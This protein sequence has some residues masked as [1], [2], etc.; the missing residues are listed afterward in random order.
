[1]AQDT[2]R[3]AYQMMVCPKL[4]YPLAVT[5][6]SQQQCDAISSPS[7]RA[8]LAKM[9]YNPNSPKVVYGLR[10]LFG[11]GLHDYYVEQGIRQLSTLVGHICQESETGKMIRIELQ[12]CQVQAGTATHLLTD[13]SPSI[14][15]IETCWIMSI[16]DFLRTYNLRLDFSTAV[17]PVLQCARD[18]FI[19]DALRV[20]GQ[21][22]AIELQHLNACRLFLQV[23]R[24][25]DIASADGLFLRRDALLGSAS[26]CYS[27][28]TRW[29]RQGHPPDVWWRLWR[30]KLKLVFSCNGVSSSLRSRLGEWYSPLDVTEWSIL[31]TPALSNRE[32]FMRRTDG[33]YDIFRH[34]GPAG[35][36]FLVSTHPVGIVDSLPNG[37]V[38]ASLG[39]RRKDGS[40]RVHFRPLSA[41]LATQRPVVPSSTFR[42]YVVHQEPHIARLLHHA[43]LSDA[44]ALQ[45]AN[46]ISACSID[47]G[48]DGG[49]L[50]D[51][52]TFGYIWGDEAS[53]SSVGLGRGQVPGSPISMSSTRTELCGILASLTHLRLVIQHCHVVIP[54]GFSCNF[55][56]DSKAA[57]QRVKDLEYN[58][59]GTTWRCRANY[60]MEAA[61]RHCLFLLPVRITWTWVKGHASQRKQAHAFTWAETLNDRADHLATNARSDSASPDHQH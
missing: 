31:A 6:F 29:P 11:F 25:S 27:S 26:S 55:F 33:N 60:D 52:G 12:W 59:F 43:D 13:T 28:S 10:D 61:I 53:Q 4:E 7:L 19:M 18:E 38:P 8:C 23:S 32:V 56:C 50:H 34:R 21:C 46:Q 20:R 48:S 2:A 14:D 30:R 36:Q 42:N 37:A 57:L 16:R 49:L 3:I 24:L 5:Q 22:T 41:S 35:H 58:G 47:C 45:L 9:G 15:Y 1:M 51:L 40:C 44:A 17:L 39:P 54:R